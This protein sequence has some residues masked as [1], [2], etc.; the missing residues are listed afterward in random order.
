MKKF[1]I[2]NDWWFY[3]VL[4]YFLSWAIWALGDS[5]LPRNLI[6]ITMLL[7]GFGPF[8]SAII[9]IR[10]L[11][12][13][14]GLKDWFKKIFHFRINYKWY[15]IG[16][17]ILPFLIAATHHIIY[18]SLGGKSGLIFSYKWLFYFVAILPTALLTGGNEEP[19]WRG[20]ITP[21]LMNRFNIYI[22]H[23]VVGFGWAI[24][25]LPLYFLG[26]WDGG[27]QSFIWLILYC[28]PL[29]IILTWL[30][31]NSKKSIIPVMLLHAG[32]NVVFRYFPMETHVLDFVKD[33]FTLIKT[34]VYYIIAIIL[35]I[36][37]RGTLGYSRIEKY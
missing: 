20:Y 37:S 30:Y 21:T 4:T 5:L 7:G 18:L 35:L 2:N 6:I 28:I 15:I 19:G 27:D 29:S 26:N 17:I 3:F 13:K 24:W 12:G 22:V 8:G 34:I 33:E 23:I 25:H 31:Y 36:V 11:N 14:T 1:L 9:I 10:V 16:A 32:T